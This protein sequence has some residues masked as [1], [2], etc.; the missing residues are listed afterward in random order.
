M[1]KLIF[2]GFY[3]ALQS[4]LLL[5]QDSLQIR[6]I[7]NQSLSKGKSYE[8]LRYLSTEIGG[9]LAGS[10]QD[11]QAV[12]WA[13]A[14]LK[15]EGLDSV[16]L[17]KVVV[18]H[19]VRGPREQAYFISK[20]GKK[21]VAVCALGGSVG[22]GKKGIKAEVVEVKNFKELEALGE[23]GVKG[24]IVFFNRAMNP[25]FIKTF[26]AYGDA[27]NQ[28]S[29][30]AIEAAK[31]GA[32]GVVVRSMASNIDEHPHTGAM[33]YKDSLTKI[34]AC[35]ISTLH[36][37][38]LSDALK[39]DPHTSFFLKQ[40]C[41][42][43]GEA[44]SYNVIGEIKGSQFPN[45]VVLV[46]GHLDAWDNGDGAHDDGAGCVQSMEVLSIYK[47]LGI[48]PKRTVRCVL[49]ANEENGLKGALAYADY[50]GNS[51]RKHI[52]AVES[53]AGG[54]TPRNFSTNAEGKKLLMLEFFGSQL[55]P[56]GIE[57]VRKGGGGADIGPL[58][59][60]GT[61][62]IGFGPDSQ[63]YFDL[64]HTAVDTFDKVSKRELELGAGNIASFIWL[65]SEYGLEE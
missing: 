6:A 7:I 4:T 26:E 1:R 49:F 30:G 59:K 61:C 40:E 16:W 17:Q 64:H 35:A 12:D 65:I 5:A 62:L 38:Q 53:D 47:S 29:M 36:A 52:A 18:P 46:G 39:N 21:T 10:P 57:E 24:K 56:Y 31:Y 14:E 27:V 15:K 33:R 50:A 54:F 55:K 8:R 43:L 44:V 48:K 19:W 51:N 34:P 60:Y 42:S 23:Q 22:T 58:G 25:L 20:S 37:E 32:V 2:L 9:R 3:F 63:R 13:F 41:A 45:E 28:R 11:K